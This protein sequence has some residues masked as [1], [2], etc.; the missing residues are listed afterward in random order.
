MLSVALCGAEAWKEESLRD[1]KSLQCHGLRC[2]A[3]PVSTRLSLSMGIDP[4]R[5][6]TPQP[7]AKMVCYPYTSAKFHASPY[8]GG[9][10][11]H[12]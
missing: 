5:I 3:S 6:E 12:Y 10:N 1:N 7:N 8:T 11:A 2:S 9:F 4:Y